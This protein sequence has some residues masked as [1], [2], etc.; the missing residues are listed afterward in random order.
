LGPL[1]IVGLLLF[2]SIDAMEQ[3]MLSS[4]ARAAAYEAYQKITPRILFFK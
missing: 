1:N 3:R 4:K 2:Y